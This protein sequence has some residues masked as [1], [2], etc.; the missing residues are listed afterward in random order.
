MKQYEDLKRAIETTV[1][2]RS[3]SGTAIIGAEGG[4]TAEWLFDFRALLLQTQW[5]NRYAEIFW[6]RY[7]S[8][9]PFQ[10][11]GM[12]SAAISLVAAIV[13]KGNERGT[14]IHGFFIRKSR[15]REGL[16]RQIEGTLTDAPVILVD[17]IINS[18]NT[19]N[20]Q[21][22]ILDE[23]HVPVSGIFA[24]L[25]YRE[26]TAY[27]FATKRGI[28]VDTLFTLKDFGIALL[29]SPS[30]NM[31]Q[32]SFDVMWQFR[33]PQPSH[34][35]VT[36]KSAPVIDDT[37]VY[38]GTDNGTFFALNQSDGSVAWT[39]DI[40]KHP[41]G[42]G[43][44]SSPALAHGMVIFGAYDGNVYALDATS[45]IPRWVYR[46][47]DWVGSSPSV[48]TDTD[49][50]YIGLEFGLI[51]K[52]GGIVALNIRTGSKKWQQTMPEFAHCSPLYIAEEKIVIMS[53]NDG[54]VYAYN[55][56]DGKERWVYRTAG[57]IQSS[58]AYDSERRYVVFGSLDKNIYI[59]S[60]RDGTPVFAYAT[61][62]GI[63]STPL[64]ERNTVYVS[65]LDK[66]V[67]AIDLDTFRVHWVFPTS[68]RIFA[69]PVV[70]EG[71]LWIG[72]NDG[73]LYELN[74]DNGTLH[75]SFQ[76]TERIV[77]RISYRTTTKRI[78][79]ATNA[80]ELY[81]LTKK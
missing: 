26:P 30:T 59:L 5:L 46:D 10:V 17:D 79:V 71:S 24:L 13:M 54:I 2:V 15:K 57:G 6:E 27:E 11:C 23:R 19:F 4:I 14:P 76:T 55:A 12:E 9:Y 58:F 74:L 69:S 7:A 81:C 78:F 52:R 47:A 25:A 8:Q 50:V 40:E 3:A 66:C 39:F 51:S 77:T 60:V 68:G 20:K 43:I 36:Q 1:L 48:S 38:F 49:T 31:P 22:K 61:G 70:F 29:T 18:G 73:R 64:V 45:G 80:N 56:A 75:A 34:Q 62:A 42:K 16:M 21:I 28:Q 32:D 53:S 65:S 67:Y 63:Y 37:R 35:W 41:E 44:F 72:S 33:A